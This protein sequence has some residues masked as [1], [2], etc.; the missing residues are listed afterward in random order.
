M[1][2]GMG[3]TWEAEGGPVSDAAVRARTQSARINAQSDQGLAC[4]PLSKQPDG[5]PACGIGEL[6]DLECR[7]LWH[8]GI[9]ER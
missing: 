2:G 5:A 6:R 7:G 1:H 8:T 3:L 9:T 4:D